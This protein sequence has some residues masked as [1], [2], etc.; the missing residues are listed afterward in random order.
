MRIEIKNNGPYFVSGTV[1]ISEAV[2][3]P[4]EHHYEY[5]PG[6]EVIPG[7]AEKYYLCRCGKSGNAPFCDGSHAGSGFDGTE[8]A[9]NLPF[10]ERVTDVTEGSTMALLDD[11]RCAFARFCHRDEGDVWTL[12]TADEDEHLRSEA[13]IAA[14]ECPAGRLAML[15][16]EDKG[17]FIEDQLDQEVV[18]LQ[19]P[20][21]GVSA[22]IAVRGSIEITSAAG[23]LYVPQNR[24]TLCRCGESS[25]KPF[26]D[27]SHVGA[28]YVDGR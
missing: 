20:E 22:G 10:T 1:P 8:T 7:N 26:C 27:A 19:D 23:E 3:T 4:V 15:S 13:I 25:N 18:I 16:L 2:I 9:E 5:V 12:T 11:S 6:D 21:K 14:N 17:E 28:G 24:V